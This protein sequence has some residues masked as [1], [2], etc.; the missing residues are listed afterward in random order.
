MNLKKIIKS[1]QYSHKTRL[2][3]KNYFLLYANLRKRHIYPEIDILKR[4]TFK[5]N[6]L[7]QNSIKV[8]ENIVTKTP[9]IIIIPIE[10]IYRTVKNP[11][12]FKDNSFEINLDTEIS[13]NDLQ[14]KLVNMGYKK[15]LKVLM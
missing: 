2:K 5:S 15:A 8:L 4:Y 13:F 14:K 3:Q 7:I 1:L 12:D 9:S 6:D 11:K 10:A